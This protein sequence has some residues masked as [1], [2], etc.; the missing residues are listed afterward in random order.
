MVVPETMIRNVVYVI[1]VACAPGFISG[2]V[3]TYLAYVYPDAFFMA[4]DKVGWNAAVLATQVWL[5]GCGLAIL[6]IGAFY[7]VK[8]R[9][10]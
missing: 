4:P 2:L 5:S 6:A 3:G 7:E 8:E 9:L 1:T 10:Q